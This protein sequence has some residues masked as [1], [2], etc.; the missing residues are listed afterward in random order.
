MPACGCDPRAGI[1]A[2]KNMAKKSTKIRAAAIAGSVGAIL[3]V[4]F[5]LYRLG[6]SLKILII[7]S[8]IPFAA[9]ILTALCCFW[10]K[11]WGRWKS[12]RGQHSQLENGGKY[13]NTQKE[14]R[15][16][17]DGSQKP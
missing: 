4:D 6:V 7:A 12:Q 5:A 3:L 2:V 9:L 15:E 11:H 1:L 16:G 14:K 8:S 10:V 17:D 13:E